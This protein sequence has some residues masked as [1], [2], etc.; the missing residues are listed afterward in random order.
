[1]EACAQERERERK[2][3]CSFAPGYIT[4]PFG[5]VFPSSSVPGFVG[6][7]RFNSMSSFQQH[8]QHQQQQHKQKKLKNSKPKEIR[9]F[10]H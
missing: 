8:Q 7:Q 10:Q 5:L 9:R 1:V 4:P 3:I 6:W 2:I